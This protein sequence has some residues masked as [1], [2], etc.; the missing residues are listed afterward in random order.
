M[1]EPP[2]ILLIGA[3]GFLGKALHR[4]FTREGIPFLGA[5]RTP[6]PGQL[7]LDLEEPVAP[8]LRETL[9]KESFSHGIICAAITD[10]EACHRDPAGSHRVNV[11]AMEEILKEFKAAGVV[12]IFFSSDL[13]FSNTEDFYAEESLPAPSTLYGKQKL[14][15]E[16]AV[17]KKFAEHLIFRTSKQMSLQPDKRNIL[18]Q[19]M[20]SLSKNEPVRSFHDQF[21]T[22]VFIE[23]IAEVTERAIRQG[24]SGTFHLAA[25]ERMSR[26]ELAYRICERMGKP[27]ELVQPVSMAEFGFSEPR[28]RIY[29]I[30]SEKIRRTLGYDFR[31]VEAGLISLI[32]RNP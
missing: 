10:I 1:N 12:P 26:L 25:P 22:P 32:P 30:D 2:K 5:A 21:I 6:G 7:K 9:S 19:V 28:G 31:K 3:G 27:R 15:M 18:S 20:E 16:E 24:L 17:R 4:H 13:V 8:Q 23:D 14:A 29:T 11:A